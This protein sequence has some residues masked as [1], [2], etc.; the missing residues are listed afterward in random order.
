MVIPISQTKGSVVAVRIHFPPTS[1]H[2]FFEQSSLQSSVRDLL[3]QIPLPGH[4]ISSVTIW[5]REGQ[6][7]VF[8]I[9]KN[10]KIWLKIVT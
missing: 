6:I 9:Y 4:A 1:S 3:Q 5:Y 8:S 10:N 7:F 2:L